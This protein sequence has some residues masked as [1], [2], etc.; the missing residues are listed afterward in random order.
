MATEVGRAEKL[1]PISCALIRVLIPISHLQVS[2]KFAFSLFDLD[3]DVF[4][5]HIQGAIN[6]VP[7]LE[8]TGIKSTVCGPGNAVPGS[9]NLL[10]SGC[11]SQQKGLG[12]A[13][14]RGQ[15]CGMSWKCRS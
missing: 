8:R 15:F 12:P 11:G 4:M 9:T 14:R 6:R 3:W 7:V 5:Q 2:E 10:P 1:L 13:K